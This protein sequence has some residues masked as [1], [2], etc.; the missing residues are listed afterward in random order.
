MEGIKIQIWIALIAQLIFSVIHRQIRESESFVT[1]V[2]VAYNNMTSYVGLV[3]IMKAHRRDG[4]ERNLEI[5]QLQL[6]GLGKGMVLE[7]GIKPPLIAHKNRF[8][9]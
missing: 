2:N 3:R 9:M 6:F 7:S 5:V 1:L 4:V 8:L